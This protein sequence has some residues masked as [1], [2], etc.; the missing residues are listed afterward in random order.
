MKW[1][2]RA[3]SL[4]S[5]LFWLLFTLWLVAHASGRTEQLLAGLMLVF[6]TSLHTVLSM[7][8]LA[9]VQLQV[10]II[11]RT[12]RILEFVDGTFVREN[13]S[14]IDDA[15]YKSAW[16][17]YIGFFCDFIL[18]LYGVSLILSQ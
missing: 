12:N 11:K 9:S 17:I 6:A 14:E 16:K 13:E 8:F 5:G 3:F 7:R 18:W 10:E 2:G 1:L 15:I 4:I